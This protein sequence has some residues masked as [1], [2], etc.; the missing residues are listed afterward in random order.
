MGKRKRSSKRKGEPVR[1]ISRAHTEREPKHHRDMEQYERCVEIW[2][3]TSWLNINIDFFC[4]LLT[5]VPAHMRRDFCLQHVN[6]RLKTD[7]KEDFV[8]RTLKKVEGLNS[9]PLKEEYDFEEPDLTKYSDRE[10]GIIND[11]FEGDPDL[12]ESWKNQG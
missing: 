8:D 5:H 2:N 12:Y 10:L 9:L 7:K 4:R 3:T 1:Y 11:A 6:K